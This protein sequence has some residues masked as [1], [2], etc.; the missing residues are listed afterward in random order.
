MNIGDILPR[1]RV[2]TLIDGEITTSSLRDFKDRW[3]ILTSMFHFGDVEALFCD[4]QYQTF[5]SVNATLLILIQQDRP[6][7]Q[8]WH[9]RVRNVQP[10]LLADPARRLS[11]SL[12]LTY[13]LPSSRCETLLVDPQSRVRFRLIHDLNLRMIKATIH[14]LQTL[15]QPHDSSRQQESLEPTLI[16]N[17]ENYG[18]KN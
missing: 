16:G 13:P 2:P 7:H 5:Q 17:V 8:D 6:F 14:V 1:Y 9:R 4:R 11:R 12:G 3:V 10:P 15:Q 18:G